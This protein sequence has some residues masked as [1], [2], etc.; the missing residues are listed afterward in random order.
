ML[1][2][3]TSTAKEL[4]AQNSGKIALAFVA[5][6][7]LFATGVLI[8]NRRIQD[9]GP[10]AA[11]R[12]VRHPGSK[13]ASPPTAAT[14]QENLT[15]PQPLGTASPKA[16]NHQALAQPASKRNSNR[17]DVEFRQN[18]PQPLKSAAALPVTSKDLSAGSENFSHDMEPDN[19]APV[20]EAIAGKNADAPV[21]AADTIVPVRLSN[22][23]STKESS[24]G[25]LFKGFLAADL[26]APDGAVVASQGA[27]VRGRIV[28]AK[29]AGLIAHQSLLSIEVIGITNLAGR[30]I[31]VRTTQWHVS[32]NHSRLVTGALLM[33]RKKQS[34][35]SDAAS[36]R[37]VTAKS[38]I[39]LA[40][41]SVIQFRLLRPLAGR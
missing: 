17:P 28:A 39:V 19:K 32:G 25:Q 11:Q 23:I 20:A 40:P 5:G 36:K 13:D 1:M 18:K 35:T 14:V 3:Q 41:D 30:S 9:R 8:S 31:P 29:R 16:V 6:F 38:D 27:E 33:R 2:E 37:G 24:T 26:L 21:A 12:V 15:R 22:S 4:L 7:L 34:S 10:A